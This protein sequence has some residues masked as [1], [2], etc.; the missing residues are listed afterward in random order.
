MADNGVD[1]RFVSVQ[2]N[3]LCYLNLS[4]Y[5]VSPPEAISLSGFIADFELQGVIEAILAITSV[6]MRYLT[7][8]YTLRGTPNSGDTQTK[9]IDQVGDIAGDVL[10]VYNTLVLRKN[11]NNDDRVPLS[12]NPF[13]PGRV[14]LSGVPEALQNNGVLN[15]SYA[16]AVATLCTVIE[17]TSGTVSVPCR[18]IMDR[19]PGSPLG[20]ARCTV[21]SVT[22][23][24]FGTQLTRKK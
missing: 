10:P 24:R 12:S 3:E 4:Y 13:K 2:Q 11:P 23:Q 22:F 21:E 8:Q 14:I 19:E 20:F 9:T 5:P 18:L 7:V 6:Q 17:S 15:P 16:A 1:V